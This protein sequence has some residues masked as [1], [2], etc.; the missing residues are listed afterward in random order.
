MSIPVQNFHPANVFKRE[1]SIMV[2]M[3]KAILRTGRYAGCNLCHGFSSFVASAK[4]CIFSR[5]YSQCRRK[6]NIVS[7]FY[8]R[9]QSMHTIYAICELNNKSCSKVV[10]AVM[11]IILTSVQTKTS[12]RFYYVLSTVSSYSSTT[13]NNVNS[14]KAMA[15]LQNIFLKQTICGNIIVR[16]KGGDNT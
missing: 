7:L 12:Y 9:F 11:I 10:I 3:Q 8:F 16:N 4:L 14:R 5:K 1:M 2:S 15:L 13:I 6:H